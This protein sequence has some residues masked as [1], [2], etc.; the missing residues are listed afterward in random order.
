MKNTTSLTVGLKH[1]SYK[2]HIGYGVLSRLQKIVKPLN[3]GNF[4]V[5]VTSDTVYGLYLN[6][7]MQ[8]FKFL[9]GYKIIRTCDGEKAKSKKWLFKIINEVLSVDCLKRRAFIVCLG[10]GTIGDMGGFAASIYKRGIPFIQVPTTLLAQIDASIGG[11]TA[12]DLPQ[13]KNIIGTFYQPK[14]VLIDPHFLKTL[15]EKEIKEGFAEAIKYGAIMDEKFFYFLKK[16]IKHIAR[17][18]PRYIN[19]LIYTCAKHKA[20]IV[21][22]DERERY[23]LRTILN[24]GHTLAHAIEAVTCYKKISHGEAV[25]VGMV[26]AAQLSRYLGKC[27]VSHVKEISS[28][29]KD[30]GL[31]VSFYDLKRIYSKTFSKKA[32]QNKN[33]LLHFSALCNTMSYDKKFISGKIRM[34]ILR[35]IGKVNVIDAIPVKSVQKTLKFFATS[36]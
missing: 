14:T 26:Y 18:E 29:I 21:S 15:D 2:I 25:S 9:D 24:Y 12:I 31:P 27:S 13:A 36:H 16:N 22:K 34:V 30:Y 19:K 17:L 1:N 32:G 7:I 10:G 33:N 28:I 3:L 8:W 20:D 35:K 11:K 23:G 6:K 5:I 4:A